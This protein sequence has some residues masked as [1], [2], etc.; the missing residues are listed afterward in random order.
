LIELDGTPDKSRLGA[1]AIL[2][3]SLAAAHAAAAARAIPL[4]RHLFDL[5]KSS[6]TSAGVAV[7]PPKIPLP[8][9]NMISGGLHAGRNLDFQDFLISPVGA[10][11]YPTALTWIVRV[12]RRLGELLSHAGYETNLVA[13]EG[14]YGPRL[15][16]SR[17]ALEFVV[18]AIEAAGLRP[19]R[20]VALALDVAA[21][22][23]YDGR[24]YATSDGVRT[25]DQMIELV[26]TLA[27]EFPIASVED[28]L[29]EDDWPA[30]RAIT[31]RLGGRVRIVGDDL[32]ATRADRVSRAIDE[33]A[34][35]A[36][37]IKVNQAGTLTETFQTMLVARKANFACIVSARSGETEDTTIADLAVATAAEQIK[38]GSV[39][40]SERLCKYNRLLRIAEE[41][42]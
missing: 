42:S 3:V 31:N 2:G 4:Y 14:G 26:A 21:T 34:A 32:L 17:E 12:Y 22:H 30:W 33:K 28:P 9:T 41:L 6:A 7:E 15:A 8:M 13:D 24:H 40:R 19:A 10:P 35:N 25:S 27:D 1:N 38:I 18:R 16:S 29:A 11:D 36:V 23:F 37:L 39:T 5:W 20:D